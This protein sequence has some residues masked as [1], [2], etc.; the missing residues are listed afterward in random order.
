[1]VRNAERLISSI[2]VLAVAGELA[3]STQQ[4]PIAE[5]STSTSSP[6][7]QVAQATLIPYETRPLTEKRQQGIILESLKFDTQ[8]PNIVV[9]ES[10]H[11]ITNLA[12]RNISTSYELI[13]NPQS[14]LQ[15]ASNCGTNR[16]RLGFH[17]LTG[18]AIVDP[19][20]KEPRRAHV[21][22]ENNIV[23]ALVALDLVYKDAQ[24]ELI[25][26]YEVEA[27]K[28][29]YALDN[30]ATLIVNGSVVRMICGYVFI[31]ES[32]MQTPTAD[33]LKSIDETGDRFIAK[34]FNGQSQPFFI[35]RKK[36]VNSP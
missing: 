22:L 8:P 3:C 27:E 7:P 1:M 5:T 35:V 14:L 26:N 25:L 15:E 2:L 34:V 30:L 21:S 11:S 24:Q 33:Q 12:V 17:I 20:S 23:S 6:K 4:R 31:I 28:T 32:G 36:I 19:T 29:I 10:L 16:T 13:L 9:G 18:D